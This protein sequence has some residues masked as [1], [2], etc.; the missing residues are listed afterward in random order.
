[1]RL[2]DAVKLEKPKLYQQD[3]VD[4]VGVVV[5]IYPHNR[6][7]R[8]KAESIC[9]VLWPSGTVDKTWRRCSELEVINEGR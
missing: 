8:G 2:G 1:M 9:R 5:E 7:P 3:L 4:A 6:T